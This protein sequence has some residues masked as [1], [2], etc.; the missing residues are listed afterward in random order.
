M[1]ELVEIATRNNWLNEVQYSELGS[2]IYYVIMGWGEG[3]S[4]MLTTRYCLSGGLEKYNY[5]IQKYTCMY[6]EGVYI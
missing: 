6:T 4:P 1:L 2:Y 5:V 3:V